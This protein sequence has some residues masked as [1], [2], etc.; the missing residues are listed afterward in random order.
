VDKLLTQKV[1]EYCEGKLIDD[2]NLFAMLKLNYKNLKTL[3]EKL[4]DD[5]ILQGSNFVYRKQCKKL[6]RV[7][8]VMP[9]QNLKRSNNIKVVILEQSLNFSSFV[10]AS[11]NLQFLSFLHCFQEI[12]VVILE[13]YNHPQAF[14]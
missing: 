4:E 14:P 2:H 12:K 5:H 3:M 9:Q 13:K 8:L 11:I 7:K 10:E 1:R 6:K